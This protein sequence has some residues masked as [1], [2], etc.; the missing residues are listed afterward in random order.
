MRKDLRQAGIVERVERSGYLSVAEAAAALS[1]TTQTIRRDFDELISVGAIIR[2]HGGATPN[3]AGKVTNYATRRSYLNEAKRAIARRLV[4]LI[5]AGSTI[6][7]ETGTTLEALAA[8]L[9]KLKIARAVTNNMNLAIMLS[10]YGLWPVEVPQGEVRASDAA[11][12]GERAVASLH[13]YRFDL[14]LIGAGAVAPD[15]TILDYDP[16]DV[17][18]ARTALALA[19][20][21]YLAADAT[22]FRHTAPLRLAPLTAITGL[23]TDQPLAPALM[24]IAREAGTA[25][26]VCQDCPGR[27][28][29]RP[30]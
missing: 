15:G 29:A 10:R 3:P 27:E 11:I 16:A 23:V 13:E 30:G 24:Q 25:L 26:H 9:P 5:P 17:A 4:E 22:K 12:L 2:H 21:S 20:Q 1:V 18:I 8:E 28:R 14:A 6:F 19:R 7:I